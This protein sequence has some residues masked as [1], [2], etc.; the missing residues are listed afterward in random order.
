MIEAA[1]IIHDAEPRRPSSINRVLRGDLETIVLKA[2]DKDREHR[3]QSVQDLASDLK[4][5]LAGE[6][7]LARAASPME[8]LSKRI[9]RNPAWSAAIAMGILTLFVLLVI[10]PWYRAEKEREKRVETEAAWKEAEK[11]RGIAEAETQKAVSA[12]K[13][14]VERYEEVI[15][16]SDIQRLRELIEVEKTLW[17]AFPENIPA[18]EAWKEKALELIDRLDTHRRTLSELRRQ[19]TFVEGGNGSPAKWSFDDAELTW[20]HGILQEL[21]VGLENLSDPEE[22]LLHKMDGRIAFAASVEAESI[23]RHRAAWDEAMASVADRETCPMYDG[24]KIEPQLGLVPIGRD[25]NSG[26]WE[27]AHLQTGEIASRDEQGRIRLTEEMGL[28]FVLIPGGTFDM[29][30]RLPSEEFPEGSP[31][32]DPHAEH[33]DL[34]VHEVTVK[35]YL[36]S[37]YEMTQGQWVRFTGENPSFTIP[38]NEFEG[39]RITFL[40]PV[41]QVSWY[42]CVEVLAR[43]ALRLP[44]EAE[45]EYVARAG[46]T[47]VRWTGD[48]ERSLEGAINLKDLSYY[49]YKPQVTIY[50]DWMDDGY[51]GEAPVGTFRPNPFGLHDMLGNVQEWCQDAFQPYDEPRFDESAFEDTS[52]MLRVRRGGGWI[53]PA[54]WCRSAFR[55]GTPASN[56]EIWGGVRPAATLQ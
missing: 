13:T 29:G 31:N 49:R 51:V 33:G 27:F 26:L 40:N 10:F 17:P 37:K 55:M 2:L 48:D 15:R 11:Q 34:F 24:L 5:F 12:E 19:G 38:G 6:V 14:A 4:S 18:M 21:V 32:V 7:I 22:G 54:R 50:E 44:S 16:L 39:K 45:W 43:L 25:P 36:L 53:T 1:R 52:D 9:K 8:R 3:Y 28:V 23:E 47:T 56:K 46:T 30:A 20:R 42:R 41:E 35:P